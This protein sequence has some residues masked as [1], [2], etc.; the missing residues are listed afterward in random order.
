[1][2]ASGDGQAPE[3]HLLVLDGT[4]EGQRLM[5][6]QTADIGR[7]VGNVVRLQDETVS[8]KHARLSFHGGQWWLEDLA[9]RNG[10]DVNGVPV[11]Q[12]LVVTY[13]DDIRFG[14]VRVRLQAGGIE[15]ESSPEDRVETLPPAA[16]V[17]A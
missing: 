10:T 11:E 2:A 13:G 9:S 1:M 4:Q 6:R 12:P 3:A 17:Q 5:L 15:G 14:Q 7:I 16:S 8:A